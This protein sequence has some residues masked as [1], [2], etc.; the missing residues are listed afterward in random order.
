MGFFATVFTVVIVSFITWLILETIA[1][2]S[3]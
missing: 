1:P 2:K 3:R